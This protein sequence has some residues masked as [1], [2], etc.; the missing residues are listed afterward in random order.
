MAY[1]KD[2]V[3]IKKVLVTHEMM[4]GPIEDVVARLK[5][6]QVKCNL[7]GYR[8]VRLTADLGAESRTPSWDLTGDRS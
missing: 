1:I 6:T 3:P 7:L 4:N 2:V 8:D 5:A